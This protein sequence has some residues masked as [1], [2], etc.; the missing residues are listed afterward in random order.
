M[1]FRAIS[2]IRST[3]WTLVLPIVLVAPLLAGCGSGDPYGVVPVSGTV[4][5][6]DG[7]LIEA[8]QILMTFDPQA[9]PVDSKT[10]P[11]PGT[12]EVNTTDGSFDNLT[13][14]A[15]GDGVI[16][17]EHKV[18]IKALDA[19]EGYTQAIPRE[20]TDVA[21]TPLTV[22]VASDST[23]FDFKIPKPKGK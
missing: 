3:V 18:T 6:D 21:T 19:N 10:F 16:L 23:T 20:Y 13:T 2:G 22:T 11:R 9:D 4:K 17:G 7:S 8:A 12:T 15:Y 14:Y 1:V 5:Y